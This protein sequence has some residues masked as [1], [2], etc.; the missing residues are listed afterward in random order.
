M[1][2]QYLKATGQ[3][4]PEIAMTAEAFISEGYQR[5]L[6]FECTGGGFD[7]Y[8]D[9]NPPNV[10]LSAI[11]ILEIKDM[12][13]VFSID[14]A[15][16]Q[17]TIDYLLYNQNP[18]GTWSFSSDAHVFSAGEG[19]LRAT[20]FALWGLAHA[21]AQGN[22]LDLAAG[23][24]QVELEKEKADTYALALGAN[25]LL[26]HDQSGASASKI[27]ENL[28][29]LAQ[30]D[31]TTTWW[32]N[33][34]PTAVYGYGYSGAVETTSLALLAFVQA[35]SH[36]DLAQGGV[37]WILAHK[38]PGGGW[39]TTQATVLALK[40]LVETEKAK[41][42]SPAGEGVVD[43]YVDGKGAGVFKI[44]EGTSD[45]YRTIELNGLVHP[46][47]VKVE[48]K[49][50]GGVSFIY[51]IV[52]AWHIPWTGEELPDS[53]LEIKMAFDK[54]TL[55]VNDIVE[56]TATVTNNMESDTGMVILDLPVPPGFGLMADKL[57]LAVE[58]GILSKYEGAGS[59]VILY[60]N[61]IPA[62]SA[63]E[64][65]YDIVALYP[66]NVSSGEGSAYCYYDPETSDEAEPVEL[67]VK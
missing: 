50:K 45:V 21:G 41:V 65:Y 19:T 48:L 30:T 35:K 37:K 44:D 39:G 36:L 67:D 23:W 4:S 14:E 32:E 11:G 22:M 46:G 61:N 40:A 60:V 3:V 25:A 8:G 47:A 28:A 5:L 34:A 2:L 15:M 66:V 7:W 18:D 16:I 12:S 62:Q 9:P 51:Q 53:P 55:S 64:Y 38:A 49:P 42:F 52:G 1:I 54:T 10:S 27:L 6:T 56:V 29:A 63:V 33:T 59:K 13:E 31:G 57:A 26:E 20:A 43:V 58:E 24:L 17:R